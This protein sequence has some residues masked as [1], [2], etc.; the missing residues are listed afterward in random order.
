MP[1][2][3]HHTV[4]QQADAPAACSAGLRLEGVFLRARHGG[5]IT[6]CS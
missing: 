3:T 1:A 4:F 2:S 6:A 5:P